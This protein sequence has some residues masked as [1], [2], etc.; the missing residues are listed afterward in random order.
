MV[1]N[2]INLDKKGI[3]CPCRAGV[4]FVKALSDIR[5]LS[6]SKWR[7]M[8]LVE[9]KP[10]MNHQMHIMYEVADWICYRVERVTKICCSV[11]QP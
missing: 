4:A 11:K 7:S 8:R 6:Q 9:S 5:K 2:I 3:A 1:L 10:R